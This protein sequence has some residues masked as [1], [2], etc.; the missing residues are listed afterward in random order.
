M[1]G[2]IT[3]DQVVV[4]RARHLGIP[5]TRTV[6]ITKFDRPNHFREEMT[7]G[8]LKSMRHDYT[9][10]EH[11]YGSLLLDKF[12]FEAPFSVAGRVAERLVLM[13]LARSFL[14]SRNQNLKRI[15]ETDEWLRYIKS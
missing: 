6:K 1:S 3:L 11:P 10:K 4:W 15:A 5:Q 13:R 8:I 9:F 12:E 14:R 2:L 7:S